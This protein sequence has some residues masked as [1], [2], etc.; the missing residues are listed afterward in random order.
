MPQ[1]AAF[2]VPLV[3]AAVSAAATAYSNYQ[4]GM[5]QDRY[6]RQM[7][8]KQVEYNQ[9][10]AKG[11][12]EEYA[13]KFAAERVGQMQAKEEAALNIQEEH[14]EALQKAGTFAASTNAQ[15][16]ALNALMQDYEAQE[17]RNKEKFRTQYDNAAEAANLNIDSYKDQ[18]QNRLDSRSEYVWQESGQ[19]LGL[20]AL[21]IGTGIALG[22]AKGYA[23]YANATPNTNG[24]S[25]LNGSIMS[26][27][28][29]GKDSHTSSYH[30]AIMSGHR[31][32]R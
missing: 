8:K 19:S 26:G 3:I 27:F 32:G 9:K 6:N 29:A 16:G 25:G 17:A 12:A 15:G 18:L 7:A 14:R 24:G 2:A 31:A 20:L 13:N 10:V 30:S 11:A 4:Q 1:A 28:K 22:A 23:G 5:A 21:Q